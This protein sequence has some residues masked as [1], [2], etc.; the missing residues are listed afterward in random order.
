[1]PVEVYEE[2]KGESRDSK[3]FCVPR[4]VREELLMRHIAPSNAPT[5]AITIPSPTLT[6]SVLNGRGDKRSSSAAEC[7]S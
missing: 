6:S 2:Y 1:M 5:P 3:E 7:P 4:S